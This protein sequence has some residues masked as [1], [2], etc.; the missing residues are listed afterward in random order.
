MP[1]K[2]LTV[3][4]LAAL[5]QISTSHIYRKCEAKNPAERWPHAR[6]ARQIRFW[7]EHLDAIRALSEASTQSP[8]RA[9][10]GR[11]AP[12]PIDARLRRI[13]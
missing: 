1:D 2:P 13:A 4:E 9:P 7:P 3:D 11:V 12:R 5:W 8:V 10:R 6:I